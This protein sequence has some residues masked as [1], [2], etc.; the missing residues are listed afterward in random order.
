MT[1][2][3]WAA[4]EEDPENEKPEPGGPKRTGLPL[5]R[6]ASLS[7]NRVNARRGPG[8]IY[9]V[10]WVFV[11]KAMPVEIIAEWELW[12]K[13]R[14]Q[15]GTSGWV[16][17][18]MLAGNRTAIVTGQVRTLYRRPDEGAAPVAQ[19]E[20]GVMGKL[21]ACHGDWCRVDLGEAKGWLRRGEIW[22]AYDKE[23]FE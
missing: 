7:S 20:P 1:G 5:P 13:I 10:D 16:H 12:R 14:D 23:E 15:D 19:A 9:P 6:F 22:G 11:R 17:K 3:A 2:A 21:L 4:S 8:K 18:S